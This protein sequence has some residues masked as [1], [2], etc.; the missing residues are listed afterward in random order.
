M[1]SSGQVL[2]P[3]TGFGPVV[4]YA[5]LSG[6]PITAA[7]MGITCAGLIVFTLIRTKQRNNTVSQ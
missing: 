1:Y 3:A 5:F 4:G 2:V 6:Y 7:V